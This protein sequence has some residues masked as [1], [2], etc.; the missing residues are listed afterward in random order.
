M[1]TIQNKLLKNKVTTRVK[2][3]MIIK[4]K[5]DVADHELS[6]KNNS[7]TS[8]QTKVERKTFSIPSEE[9]LILNKLK[10]IALDYKI[11]MSDSE[12]IR[13][14]L[15]EISNMDSSKLCEKMTGL[16]KIKC[17]RPKIVK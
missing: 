17:G 9:L 3:K 13:V 11:V 2:E 15:K 10:D 12:I 8:L 1:S 7:V 5:F 14:G 16:K 4:D 6:V